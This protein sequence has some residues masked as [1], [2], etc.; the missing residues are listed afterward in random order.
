MPSYLGQSFHLNFFQLSC[1]SGRAHGRQYVC[2]YLLGR[3]GESDL[4]TSWAVALQGSSVHG[5]LQERILEWV[6]TP[7]SRGSSRPRDQ[8]LVSRIGRWILHRLE[9][10][11][12]LCTPPEGVK[13]ERGKHA[14]QK[15]WNPTP[16]RFPRLTDREIL[17]LKGLRNQSGSWQA[18][19]FWEEFLQDG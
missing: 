3:S 7:F 1:H 14:L 4:A 6:A 5:I 15:T 16:D 17:G 9:P 18:S 10:P 13:S 2:V 12:N 8:T 11:G 19:R